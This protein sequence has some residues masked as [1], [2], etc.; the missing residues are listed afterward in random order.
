MQV[1]GAT[2][3]VRTVRNVRDQY[4]RE[5]AYVVGVGARYGAYVEF[6]TSKMKPQPYLMPATRYVLRS[7]LPS[8]ANEANSIEDIV[9]MT[10]LE[11]EAQAKERAP[12]DT[13]KLKNSIEAAPLR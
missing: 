12:V 8:I 4:G 2:A 3:A 6:G 11:I 1:Q 7:E 10:A 13:G 9:R 5:V